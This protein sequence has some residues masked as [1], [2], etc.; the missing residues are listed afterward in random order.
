MTGK[1]APRRGEA[2]RR[3][4]PRLARRRHAVQLD[5]QLGA[6]AEG[7]RRRIGLGVD[8]AHQRGLD[9][10][11]D[12][13]IAPRAG[14]YFSHL[15]APRQFP[16]P[17]VMGCGLQCADDRV[18]PL[19]ERCHHVGSHL[20]FRRKLRAST[21]SWSMA[22]IAWKSTRTPSAAGSKCSSLTTCWRLAEPRPLWRSS[23]N[24]WAVEW[25]VWDSLSNWSF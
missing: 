20:D 21:I 23:W 6:R 14:G 17:R 22:R 12:Q 9:A 10:D 19:V 16:P 25:R 1:S 11:R 13:A 5:A 8:A 18:V 3:D 15:R 2:P 7:C 24:R 4:P